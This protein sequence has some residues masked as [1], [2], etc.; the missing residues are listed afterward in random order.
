MLAL[1]EKCIVDREDKCVVTSGA[2]L[3]KEIDSILAAEATLSPRQLLFS[4]T[5]PGA[6]SDVAF[7]ASVDPGAAAEAPAMAGSLA[8][9]TRLPRL[10]GIPLFL[11]RPADRMVG[12]ARLRGTDARIQIAV[13]VATSDPIQPP[14]RA[15]TSSPTGEDSWTDE[16]VLRTTS[17]LP[18]GWHELSVYGRGVDASISGLMLYAG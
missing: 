2:A 18:P 13:G 16:F 7:A 6:A 14:L 4:W 9:S 10:S 11:G 3:L 15:A 12:R 8:G 5:S 1:L 17:P